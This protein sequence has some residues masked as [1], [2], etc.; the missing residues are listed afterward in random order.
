V[1]FPMPVALPGAGSHAVSVTGQTGLETA[2]TLAVDEMGW[3]LRPLPE[4]AGP[5]RI[6]FGQG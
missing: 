6:T 1:S 4:A 3:S 5:V 2:A